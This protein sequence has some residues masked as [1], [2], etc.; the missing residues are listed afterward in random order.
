MND[1]N[2]EDHFSSRIGVGG[3]L[4][5]DKINLVAIVLDN[6]EIFHRHYRNVIKYVEE[7]T[8]TD[9]KEVKGSVSAIT[10]VNDN[11]KI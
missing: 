4:N 9:V 1:C 2:G 3:L 5:A 8:A 7:Q 10:S 11:L 6:L